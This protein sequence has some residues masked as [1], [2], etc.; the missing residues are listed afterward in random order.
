LIYHVR[1]PRVDVQPVKQKGRV[2][3]YEEVTVDQGVTDKRLLVIEE[4]FSQPLKV[5]AREGN[6]LSPVLRQ[7]WDSG[8]LHP[9]TKSSPIRA[10]GAHISIVGHITKDELLRHLNSTEQANGFANRFLWLMVKRSKLIDDPT[11]VP[12]HLLS[13]L[14]TKLRHAMQQAKTLGQMRRDPEAS[15]M[16]K[17]VYPD[18]S[19][20]QPGLFGA[21][22]ARAEAQVMRL[23]CIYAACDQTT[24]VSTAHLEAGLAIWRYC[25][26]SAR[27]IFGDALGDPLA[28]ELLRVLRANTE[29]ATRTE[30]NRHF[31]SHKASDA[32]TAALI[33]LLEFQR[34]ECKQ[35]QTDGRYAER[36]IAVV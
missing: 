8:D 24:I 18:L 10:T 35:E 4:E 30:L 17:A 15:A 31:G 26:A 32:I 25:E 33:K 11:G 3:D 12:A 13:P 19:A 9:L 27:G 2:I 21:I 20:D 36:W 29:G 34:V 7:G 22:T 23:A 14:V 6:I 5:M 16:W 1:D 28:D